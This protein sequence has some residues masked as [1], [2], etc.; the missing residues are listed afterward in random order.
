MANQSD[1][2]PPLSI[3]RSGSSRHEAEVSDLD[4]GASGAGVAEKDLLWVPDRASGTAAARAGGEDVD[5]IRRWV[6]RQIA[7]HLEAEDENVPSVALEAD[8]K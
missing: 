7:V 4:V 2:T 5:R 8:L 6:A 1:D 3:A